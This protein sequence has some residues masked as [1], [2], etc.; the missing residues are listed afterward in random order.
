M[1]LES[2]FRCNGSDGYLAWIDNL[3]E[4]KETANYDGFDKEYDFKVIEDINDLKKII[5]EKNKLKN[6]ARLL[7]G[8]CWNWK[9]E[10]RNKTESHD[11][12]IGDFS[13]SWNL[14]N[15][16]TWAIDENSV[17]EVGCIHTSQ[18]L[19]FDYIGVI[20]GPDLKYREG[21]IITDYKCRAK[22]DQ[23]IKGIKKLAKEHPDIAKKKADEIIKNTYRTLMTRGQKG[24]Y[25]YCCDKELQEYIKSKCQKNISHINQ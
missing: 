6:K 18:G 10:D 14:E 1:Q 7:A 19:E 13:M 24:C 11:I 8:Y 3:L 15:T 17:N 2:Q 16:G 4:I 23:S 9:K 22:T 25:I 5:F 20:I 21:K 12:V